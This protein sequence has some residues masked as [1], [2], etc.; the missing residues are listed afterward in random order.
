M[1]LALLLI[2]ALCTA[3][4]LG[5]LV[6]KRPLLYKDIELLLVRD[7]QGR[8]VLAL[9]LNLKNIKISSGKSYE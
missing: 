8:Y 7:G 5:A 4:R 6:G 3:T 9:K 2:F 1:Q